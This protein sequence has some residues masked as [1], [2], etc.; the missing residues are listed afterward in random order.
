MTNKWIKTH[1]KHDKISILINNLNSMKYFAYYMFK[2]KSNSCKNLQKT[3][4]GNRRTKEDYW[5]CN[6]ENIKV[7][8]SE[9]P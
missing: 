6:V 5:K 1:K 8:A 3:K 9:K 4:R 2:S 7:K